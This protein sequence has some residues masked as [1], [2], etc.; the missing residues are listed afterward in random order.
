MKRG[1]LFL[2]FVLLSCFIFATAF[3]RWS[4]GIEKIVQEV[5]RKYGGRITLAA[6]I[7]SVPEDYLLA[8]VVVESNGQEDAVSSTG[9]KGLTM[10]TQEVVNL[11]FKESGCQVDRLHPYES[12][13]GAAW[14]IRFLQRQYGFIDLEMAIGAYHY[15]P[16]GLLRKL[17]EQK[18]IE[19][20]YYIRKIKKILDILK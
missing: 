14:Y 13:W 9:V 11:I 20:L 18:K 2:V 15:G 6:S 1:L 10:L 5:Q 3:E 4:N 7:H 8:L 12:L 17:K 19:N 16:T